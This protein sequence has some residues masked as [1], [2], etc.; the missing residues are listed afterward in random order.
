[1]LIARALD[2]PELSEQFLQSV[3]NAWP[4]A[5]EKEEQASVSTAT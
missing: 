2:N 5:P 1:M 4:A 3:I